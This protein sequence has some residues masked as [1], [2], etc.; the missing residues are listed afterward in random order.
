M[1]A[2]V[3]LCAPTGEKGQLYLLDHSNEELFADMLKYSR[4]YFLFYTVTKEGKL[5]LWPIV[6]PHPDTETWH[7][8]PRTAAQVAEAVGVLDGA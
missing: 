8:S 4:N 6:G 2:N 7:Q 1:F 5:S 3:P